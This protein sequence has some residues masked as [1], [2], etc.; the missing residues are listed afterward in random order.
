M[1]EP[2]PASPASD[3]DG[4]PAHRRAGMPAPR[5]AVVIPVY[6]RADLAAR[7]AASG[8]CAGRYGRVAVVLVDDA[9]PDGAAGELR[10]AC[11]SATLIERPTNGGFAAAVNTGLKSEPARAAPYVALLNADAVGH[12]GWLE[13]CVDELERDPT[14]GSVCPLI[15]EASDPTRIDSAGQGVTIGGWGFRVA[16]GERAADAADRDVLG[17][18]GCA[19]VYRREALERAGGGLREDLVAYY[20]D[21]ELALRLA[22]A[23]FGC[24]CVAGAVVEHEGSAVYGTMPKAKARRVSRNMTVVAI[25][26]MPAQRR[27]AWLCWHLLLCALH[28][29]ES[30]RRGTAGAWVRGK[31][32]AMRALPASLRRRRS[33]PRV[34]MG[35]FEAHPLR[36]VRRQ[37]R[38]TAPGRRS[39]A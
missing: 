31:L 10:E 32:D 26:H 6:G 3:T 36:A 8:A 28:A 16:H 24:R 13:A 39:R 5:V 21:A 38:T 23:G 4:A 34:A 17:P 11:P 15:V 29:G 20:E 9:S 33:Q 18:T 19:A 2:D 37:R 35:L 27:A 14:L 25:E 22:G 30:V 7:A 1:P 12:P